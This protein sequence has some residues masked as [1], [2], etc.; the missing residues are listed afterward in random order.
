MA[1]IAQPRPASA[2]SNVRSPQFRTPLFLAGVGLALFAFLA[3]FTFGLIFATRSGSGAQ[4]TAVVAAQPI[5]ARDPLTAD[6]LATVKVPATSALPN[7]FSAVTALSGY[8]AVVD[9]P[10]G[11][12][13]TQNMVSQDP[14]SLATDVAPHPYIPKGYILVTMPTNEQQGVAG[15]I[16]KGSYVDVIVTLDRSVVS[17]KLTGSATKTVFTNVYVAFVGP[18]TVVQQ[19]GLAQGLSSSLTVLLSECDAEYLTWFLSNGTVKYTLLSDKENLGLP[20]SAPDCPSTSVRADE[21]TPDM[22]NSR[23]HFVGAGA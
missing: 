16:A 23:F 21:V 20:T 5:S 14:T 15:Y 9:I 22:V 7:T 18:Q 17:K 3:M 13:I 4:I 6:M 2:P 19:H 1:T 10:K 11:Q 12:A 8:Y